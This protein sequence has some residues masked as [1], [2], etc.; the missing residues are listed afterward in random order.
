MDADEQKLQTHTTLTVKES[1]SNRKRVNA[2]D[3]HVKY[4]SN[5][6]P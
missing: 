4:V 5:L 6:Y 1:D 2:A 3:K